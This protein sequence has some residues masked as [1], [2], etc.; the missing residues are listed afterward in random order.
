LFLVGCPGIEVGGLGVRQIYQ[1]LR[2]ICSL[3]GKTN[4]EPSN[5]VRLIVSLMLERILD[6]ISCHFIEEELNIGWFLS[7]QICQRMNQG[8]ASKSD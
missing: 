6:H 1:A 5:G 8:E 4:L 2:M 3:G 7:F